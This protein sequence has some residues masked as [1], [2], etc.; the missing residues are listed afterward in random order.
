MG[1]SAAEKLS[2]LITSSAGG[3][4]KHG[5]Q[6][7]QTE[8]DTFVWILQEGQDNDPLPW[9]TSGD[10]YDFIKPIILERMGENE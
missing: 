7:T 6:M 4:R 9:Y 5:R 2:V 3:I 1:I 8:V 10:A